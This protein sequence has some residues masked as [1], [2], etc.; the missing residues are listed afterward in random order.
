M[1]EPREKGAR[2]VP[3]GATLALLLAAWGITTETRAQELTIDGRPVTLEALLEH[4]DQHAPAVAV[5]RARVGLADEALGA[6]A[7][8]LPGNPELLVGVGPRFLPTGQS[9]ANVL[10]NL[11][12][13]LEIAGERPLRFDVARAARARRERGL[14]AVR[15]ETRAAITAS[16]RRAQLARREAALAAELAAFHERWVDVARRRVEAGDAP[17]LDRQLAEADAARARQAR[18]A[19]VQRYREACLALAG[20]AGWSPERPPEP[21][22]ALPTPRSPPPL[23]ALVARALERDPRLGERR[24]ALEEARTREALAEREAWPRP[25]IG[26][27]YVFEGAPGGGAPEHVLMGLVSLPIPVAQ[28]GQPERARAAARTDVERAEL[29]AVEA[30][31][32]ARLELR[33]SAVEAAAER[34]RV[35]G[36]GVLPEFEA[37]LEQLERAFALGEIDALRLAMTAERFLA[38]QVEAL[39]A[40]AAYVDAVSALELALGAELR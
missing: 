39:E 20:L 37:S 29:D 12:V 2:R 22:G 4:A 40:L 16:Y 6:A 32:A 11:L 38:A 26:A 18:I 30:S 34:V 35:F 21:V 19:A 33:R 9:D 8:L 7:P 10:V 1:R 24:A 15:W 14:D 17:P 28:L 27:R 13:P 3:V 31:L 36:E 23:Q 25:A 5:A